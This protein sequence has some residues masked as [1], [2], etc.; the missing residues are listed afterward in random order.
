MKTQQSINPYDILP[1]ISV[2]I[3]AY[4]CAK[5]LPSTLNSVLNQAGV[6]TDVI[7]VDDGSTDNTAEI[8]SAYTNN[9]RYL[10]QKNAGPAAARNTGLR[11]AQ[12]D[13]LVFLDADDLLL[14][15]H[16][17]SQYQQLC[18]HPDASMVVCLNAYF[19][20]ENDTTP[21]VYDGFWPLVSE[22]RDIHLCHF[23]IM[24]IHS[25][26]ITREVFEN[27]GFFD[28][29]LRACEDHDY[30]LRCAAKGYLPVFNPHSM[31]LYRRYDSSLSTKRV[32]EHLHNII[33]HEYV[34]NILN[35]HPDFLVDTRMDGWIAHAAGCLITVERLQQSHKDC[36][37]G[38]ARMAMRA[39]KNAAKCYATTAKTRE[40]AKERNTALYYFACRIFIHLKM[41]RNENAAIAHDME[42]IMRK[43]FPNINTS[44]NSLFAEVDYRL[45]RI[46]IPQLVDL[47]IEALLSGA[48]PHE[49]AVRTSCKFSIV[50]ATRNADRHLQ[51]MVQS[52]MNQRY[53]HWE[54]I[55]QDGASTDTTL[56]ILSN[57]DDSRINIQSAPDDGVYDAWNK[58]LDRVQ[59]DWILFLGADDFL[60]DSNVLMRAS[61]LLAEAPPEK[62]Y[63]YGVL[64]LGQGGK[65]EEVYNRSVHEVLK[66]YVSNMGLPFPATFARATLFQ[67]QKFDTSYK[68]AGDFAFTAQTISYEN[69]LRLPMC[70]SYMEGGG[71]STSHAHQHI[72]MLERTRVLEQCVAP[73]GQEILSCCR[74]SVRDTACYSF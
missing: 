69:V 4:N 38:V 7:V 74:L 47:D 54:L 10:L 36:A 62:M 26:M 8:M 18:K 63:A 57:Y 19:R 40:R 44:I 32:H 1:C 73:R 25:L 51:K 65:I 70:V 28:D 59:G 71:L 30:W 60:I 2:I 13:Y 50:L 22:D 45:N 53:Q 61:L 20:Q 24:P 34:E 49:F 64:C 72:L 5:F 55:V 56:S 35:S 39:I 52:L 12:G 6:K 27:V 66:N 21:R 3:P 9:V 67:N 31:V 41:L 29:K 43:L 42:D 46:L 23:N 68:I 37:K 16:L 11:E 15:N 58:A 14:P 48:M 17:L 33:L